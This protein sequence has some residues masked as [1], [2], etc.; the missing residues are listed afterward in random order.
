MSSE[1]TVGRCPDCGSSNINAETS[2]ATAICGECGLVLDDDTLPSAQST[3]TK[4]QAA[5]QPGSDTGDAVD[6][7]ETDTNGWHSDFE[8]KDSSDEHLVEALIQ[9]ETVAEELT[10]TVDSRLRAAEL[11]TEA[12]E[13]RFMHGRGTDATVA[14][15]LYTACRQSGQPRPISSVADTTGVCDS[16]L[17]SIYRTLVT[18]LELQVETAESEDY[19]SYLSTQLELDHE[20]AT[21]AEGVLTEA[22]GVAGNPVG[23]AAAALYIAANETVNT[24]T[25]REAAAVTGVTKETIWRKAESLRR[26]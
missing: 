18:E 14:T 5:S 20:T 19:I 6:R 11:L 2:L 8:V 12:W 7:P 26:N 21:K 4:T 24:I 9:M 25:F 3:E 15:C 10:M 13:Q 22:Q 23:I 17:R 16:K 1:D